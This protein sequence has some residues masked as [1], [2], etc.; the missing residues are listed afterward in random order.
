MTMQDTAHF[1]LKDA[2]GHVAEVKA[3]GKLTSNESHVEE[4]PGPLSAAN[5]A[6]R[7]VAITLSIVTILLTKNGLSIDRELIFLMALS[8]G[9]FLW[10]MGRSAWIGWARLERLHHLLEQERWEVEHRREQEREELKAL[11]AAKGFEGKLLDD[12]VEVLMAD[13]DRLLR[14]MVEEELGLSLEQQ[15]HPLL[16]AMGAGLGAFLASCLIL[17][18][19]FLSPVSGGIL[20]GALALSLSALLSSWYEQNRM[21]ASLF[22]LLGIA[23]LAMGISFF[24]LDWIGGLGGR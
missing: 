19:Y 8:L 16:Q 15:D 14:V 22:W 10:K 9:L 17:V 11:Y 6:W 7:D 2:M 12:V 4:L 13:Q 1:G 18:S 23:A 24:F 5:D 20:G 3:K 21:V